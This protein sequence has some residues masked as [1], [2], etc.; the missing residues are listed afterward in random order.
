MS[1][2]WA[3][4]G[5]IVGIGSV[6]FSS[7][8]W[9]DVTDAFVVGDQFR[10]SVNGSVVGETS[11]PIDDGSTV[12]SDADAAFLNPVVSSGTFGPFSGTRTVSIEVIDTATGFPGGGAFWRTNSVPEPATLGML[13]L[14]GLAMLRRRR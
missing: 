5:E 7:E 10:V 11:V 12:G 14:G 4:P 8:P 3:G 13:A 9:L 6:D 2:S 1:F